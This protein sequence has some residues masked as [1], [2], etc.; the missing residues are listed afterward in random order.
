MAEAWS[1]DSQFVCRTG[2]DSDSGPGW[3]Q[4][5]DVKSGQ[6]TT[7][8]RFEK[9]LSQVHWHPSNCGIVLFW[10]SQ[11]GSSVQLLNFVL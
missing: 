11:W 3:L 10:Y 1:S 6:V 7:T 5:V 9:P 4:I 8:Y 2:A